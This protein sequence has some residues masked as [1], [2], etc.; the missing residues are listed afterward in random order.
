MLLTLDSSSMI[1]QQPNDFTVYFVHA[2]DGV[3]GY[4]IPPRVEWEQC[5]SQWGTGTWH[6]TWGPGHVGGR[7]ACRP[8]SRCASRPPSLEYCLGLLVSVVE[9]A[10]GRFV[11]FVVM[12]FACE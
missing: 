4:G 1:G 9:I 6:L 8:L 5:G 3:R 12:E 10:E 11:W 7:V 2:P